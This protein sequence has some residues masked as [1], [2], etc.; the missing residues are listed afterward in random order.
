MTWRRTQGAGLRA[1]YRKEDALHYIVSSFGFR[2]R[3][4]VRLRFELAR[5]AS[6]RWKVTCDTTH[7]FR[8]TST[9]SGWPSNGGKWQRVLHPDDPQVPASF[10]SQHVHRITLPCFQSH[11]QFMQHMRKLA[12]FNMAFVCAGLVF[13]GGPGLTSMDVC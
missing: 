1:I 11:R 5:A 8:T 7:T 4:N 2:P 9:N 6:V 10:L 12:N 3:L 13:H